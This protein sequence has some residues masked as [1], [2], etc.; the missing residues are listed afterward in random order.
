MKRFANIHQV[1]VFDVIH[2]FT[3]SAMGPTL[4]SLP[5]VIDY[6]I[7]YPPIYKAIVYISDMYKKKGYSPLY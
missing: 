2:H 4:K 7:G 3:D 1:E 6:E 5:I